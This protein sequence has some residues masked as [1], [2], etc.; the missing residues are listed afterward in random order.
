MLRRLLIL[1]VTMGVAAVAVGILLGRPLEVGGAERPLLLGEL[2]GLLAAGLFALA[3]VWLAPGRGAGRRRKAAFGLLLA[4]GLTAVVLTAWLP[5]PPRRVEPGEVEPPPGARR[6]L[7]VA[8]DALS[9]N[10][11]LPLARSGALPN[12]ARLMEEGSY[13]ALDSLRSRRR[14]AGR[15]GYWSPVVWTSIATGLPPREHGIVDFSLPNEGGGLTLA[16]THHRRAAAFWNL[17]SA[18]GRSVGVVGWWASWPAEE[19]RGEIVSS[20]LGLR[21]RRTGRGEELAGGVLERFA[22]G[23]THPAELL[24]ELESEVAP[25]GDVERFIDQRIFPLTSYAVLGETER[26]TFQSVIWQDRYFYNVARYLLQ[27][28]PRE[29]FAVYFEGVDLAG[30]LWWRYH[31]DP[32]SLLGVTVPPGFAEHAKVVD[33]SYRVVDSY[34]GGLMD[35]AGDDATVVVV[36]DHGFRSDPGHEQGADHSV[37]GVILARGP[38]IRR[39]H[40]L[41]LSPRGAVDRLLAGRVGVLD[42]LPTLLYLHGLPVSRELPGRPVFE[43]LESSYLRRNPLVE[44]GSY[45]DFEATRKVEIELPEEDREE[46]LERLRSLGYID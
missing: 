23:L 13:G 19:V 43:M 32:D 34:L 2:D 39:G 30:H 1:L 44:V 5:R 7:L 16:A 46:Y 31:D 10:R 26:N 27:R 11:L 37:S 35:L 41:N 36:S 40:D 8:V 25:P 18:F 42:V 4:A 6:T 38:G 3:L 12:F 14:S 24:V 28:Q 20:G 29:L 15:D 33:R 22:E 45:G 9:W 21:G 17:W